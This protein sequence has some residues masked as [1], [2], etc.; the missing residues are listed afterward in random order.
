[1]SPPDIR[2]SKSD[3]TAAR[4]DSNGMTMALSDRYSAWTLCGRIVL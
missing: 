2:L 3:R 1:M 4:T